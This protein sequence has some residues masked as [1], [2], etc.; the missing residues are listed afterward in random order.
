[1]WMKDFSAVSL[2]IVRGYLEAVWNDP[3]NIYMI[4]I[5]LL[6]IPPN[7]WVLEEINPI[8]G[9]VFEGPF[10]QPVRNS[11]KYMI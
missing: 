11:L 6:I 3:G 2:Q 8:P 7:D 10:S 5:L 9:D 1:M 4:N